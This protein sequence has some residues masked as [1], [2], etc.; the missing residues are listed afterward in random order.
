MAGG[1]P[2]ISVA[3]AS[4][5]YKAMKNRGVAQAGR[6]GDQGSIGSLRKGCSGSR[7]VLDEVRRSTVAVN[8]VLP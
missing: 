8:G 3:S 7:T 2:S 6:L 5:P 4:T 1:L